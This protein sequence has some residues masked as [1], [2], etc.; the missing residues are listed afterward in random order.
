MS[1]QAVD[2]TGINYTHAFVSCKKS[3]EK[4]QHIGYIE[5]GLSDIRIGV[6]QN[7]NILINHIFLV[8]LY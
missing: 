3:C 5:S 8:I 1:W 7:I 2:M 6:G 4:L